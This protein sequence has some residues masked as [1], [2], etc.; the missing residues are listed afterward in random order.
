MFTYN[1]GFHPYKSETQSFV[2]IQHGRSSSDTAVMNHPLYPYG[3]ASN[4]I[5]HD[6]MMEETPMGFYSSNVVTHHFEDAAD[7]LLGLL[8][9]EASDYSVPLPIRYYP[10]EFEEEDRKGS[11]STS[12]GPWRKRIALWMY[13]V[14]DHFKYDRNVV[15]IALRYID[16]YVSYLLM[17]K[18]SSIGEPVVKRRHFQLIA[19]TSLYLAIKINGELQEEPEKGCEPYD[20]VHALLGE[21]DGFGY[22]GYPKECDG[23]DDEDDESDDEMRALSIKI[24]DL[25]RRHRLG[26]LNRLGLAEDGRSSEKILHPI[27]FKPRKRGMLSG[28]LRLNSFVELSRGLFTS[29]DIT[30]TEV[31]I[32]KALNYVVNPPTSRRFIG[33]LVRIF[34]FCC[35]AIG[36]NNSVLG[37]GSHLAIKVGVDRCQIM[38]AIF[39]SSCHQTEGAASVPSLSLGCLPSVVAYA[40]VLNAIEEVLCKQLGLTQ[41]RDE[42]NMVT[43]EEEEKRGSYDLEDFQRHYRRYSRSQSAPIPQEYSAQT[44]VVNKEEYM[45]AWKDKF[46]I[47]V[48]QASNCFLAPD[49]E[50]IICV[51]ELLLKEVP[52]LS[53]DGAA[54][55]ITSPSEEKSST[56]ASST[57]KRSPRS[58]RSVMGGVG[59][60]QVRFSGSSSFFS[61]SNSSTNMLQSSQNHSSFGTNKRPNSFRSSSTSQLSS[62]NLKKPYFKQ[63]SAP[64][65]TDH[66]S[67]SF[68]TNMSQFPARASTPEV[69][70]WRCKEMGK[71]ASE[72][73]CWSSEAFQPPPFF[74]A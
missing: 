13:D 3:E 37:A 67:A 2:P 7:H 36:E 38:S 8:Q 14:V 60:S 33:E 53:T 16:Q 34:G 1:N 64:L 28:P 50:D 59:M 24:K 65:G 66:H 25:R 46:V 32:L 11:K 20:F 56:D 27:P 63:S 15:S 71:A 39:A 54:D 9:R 41:I 44:A 6:T 18:S 22:K 70:H 31:K 30:D 48:F 5:Y 72:T 61:R 73:G 51:R 45:E 23:L 68:L 17:R 4:N 58:P 47:A 29:R 10:T 40:A 57:K 21:V 69:P 62:S 43:D 42:D 26:R 49:S 19:V 35:N 12:I 74:S 52:P 55:S